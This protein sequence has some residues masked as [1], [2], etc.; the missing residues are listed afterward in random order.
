MAID[1]LI[2][3]L[4]REINKLKQ[5][6]QI[7]GGGEARGFH[8]ILRAA[9]AAHGICRQRLGLGFRQLKR[10]DGRNGKVRAQL[11][12]RLSPVLPGNYGAAPAE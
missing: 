11:H 9:N 6:R 1:Q 12:S 4:D 3:Q 7:L 8:H 10:H 5:A 2:Q